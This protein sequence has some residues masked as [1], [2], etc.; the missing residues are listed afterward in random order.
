MT[1]VRK[2]DLLDQI[3]P[4]AIVGDSG[5]LANKCDAAGAF[6]GSF[7]TQAGLLG[8][9]VAFLAVAGRAGGHQILPAVLAASAAR[10]N[11]VNC[12]IRPALAAILAAMIISE[13]QILAVK[14]YTSGGSFYITSQADDSRQSKHS[15]D[16]VNTQRVVF[17]DNFN[18]A[19]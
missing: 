15:S 2:P 16:S 12:Q 19:G 4:P 13:K 10:N 1:A 5:G 14:Q 18:R 17:F 11:V 3:W 7:E 6:W 9:A 8:S